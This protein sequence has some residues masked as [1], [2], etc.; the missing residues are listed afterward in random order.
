MLDIVPATA[1]ELAAKDPHVAAAM[2]VETSERVQAFVEELHS[3]SFMSVPQ[4]VARHVLDLAAPDSSA[5]SAASTRTASSRSTSNRRAER[6]RGRGTKVTDPGEGSDDNRT[7]RTPETE[8]D[9]DTIS[10]LEQ[11]AAQWRSERAERQERTHLQRADF[12]A[13]AATGYLRA[14]VPE[15]S[16]GTWR[17]IDGSVTSLAAMVRVL[18][19]ADPSVALVSSMHPAVLAFWLTTPDGNHGSAAQRRAVFATAVAGQRW[20]TITSEPGTGGDVLRTAATAEPGGPGTSLPGDSYMVSGVK[21]FGSGLGVVD[22]MISTAVPSGAAEPALFVIDMKDLPWDGSAG[23]SL[24]AEWDG[25]GMRATQSHG[26]RL[27]A[28]RATRFAS[29]GTLADVGAAAN[30]LILTLFAAAMLGVVDEAVATA[31]SRLHDRVDDLGPYERVQWGRATQLHWLAAQAL[32]GSI[33]S[34]ASGDHE[35]AFGAS[36]WARSRSLSSPKRR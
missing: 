6:A 3:T 12:D 31:R 5:A 13:I 10:A 9:R 2:L 30:P 25:A 21:H 28:V 35:A 17:G 14:A 16:G 22:W 34:V 11:L 24:V 4:R 36:I 33:L 8:R 7:M 23:M 32:E 27:E 26:V 18:A 29:E 19:R 1:A 15:E 20:G